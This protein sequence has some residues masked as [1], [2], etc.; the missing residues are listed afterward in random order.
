MNGLF[1]YFYINSNAF[2][3]QVASDAT[4]YAVGVFIEKEK[5]SSEDVAEISYSMKSVGYKWIE[6]PA[7]SKAMCAIFPFKE[8]FLAILVAVSKVY[9]AMRK[10][11]QVRNLQRY[12]LYTP[13]PKKLILPP[14]A[15]LIERSCYF[16]IDLMLQLH[17]HHHH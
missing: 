6:V 13:I 11:I 2:S 9:P 1:N 4:C 7:I 3:S 17:H 10:Y 12:Y 8:N 5:T 16:K 15:W 14:I